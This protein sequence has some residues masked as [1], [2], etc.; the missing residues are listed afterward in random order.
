M[1]QQPWWKSA[2]VYQIYPRSFQDSNGDGVGDLNG[3][4]SRLDVLAE[5]G[6][7]ALW[8]SPV[9]TS[10]MADFGYDISD[11][12]GIDPLFGTLDDFDGLLEEAHRRGLKVLL[13]MVLNHSSDQ[14][15]WFVESRS[16]LSN[17]KR[18]WYVWRRGRRPNNWQGVFGGRAWTWDPTTESWYLHSFLKEQPDLNWRNADLRRAVFDDL[19]FWLGRGVDG[20]RFDVFNLWFKDPG[21]RSNPLRFCG[22]K[23][24]RPYDWQWHRHDGF[25]GDLHPVLRELRTLLDR[26]GAAGVGEAYLPDGWDPVASAAYLGQGDELPL[27][28]DFSTITTPWSARA[29][30]RTLQEW[31]NAVG[32]H[33]SAFVLSNHDQ[34]RAWTRL[35]PG[36]GAEEADARAR[37]AAAVLLLS[38]GTPFLY[39]GEELGMPEVTLSRDQ[40]RDPVGVR[41]WPFNRGR[42]GA[43]TPMAWTPGPSGGFTTGSPWLPLHPDHQT[44]NVAV[45]RADPNSLWNWHATLLALRRRHETLRTGAWEPAEAGHRDVLAFRRVAGGERWLVAA[46]FRSRPTPILLEA[47]GVWGAGTKPREALAAGLHVLDPYEVLVLR[48]AAR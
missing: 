48:E 20:F 10:P 3:I 17:P 8:L 32:Q 26:Y 28:F 35:S 45:Q 33:G 43:R 11:Y 19:E 4:T 27:V 29:F 25:H 42:D 46:N 7:D 2:V 13:D 38:G 34:P 6:V 14:H 12:R 9:Q 21:L 36:C 41:Y 30:A 24:P 1:T 16:S 39:Y 5:L 23:N 15:P 37:V 47:A 31:K 40:I 18:D 22:A 44:R